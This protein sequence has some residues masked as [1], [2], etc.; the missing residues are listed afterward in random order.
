[1]RVRIAASA[2]ILSLA[3][4]TL[5]IPASAQVQPT[6][7]SSG[8]AGDSPAGHGSVSIAF[9]DTA[10]NGFWLRSNLKL[11][12]GAVHMLGTGL[13]ASY[14]VSDDWTIYG[15]V[16]YFTGRPGGPF[17]NCPTLAPPQCAGQPPLANPHPGIALPRRRQ[18]PRRLA[19]LEPRR[20][21]ARQHRQLLHHAV[22][23][24]VHPDPRLSNLRQR[25]SGTG[26][27]PVAAG[28]DA[29]RTSSTSPISTTSS[30]TATRSASMCLASIPATSASTANWAGSSTRSSRCAAS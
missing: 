27:A 28:C 14:N 11:P 21:L 24:G 5:A 15:G 18:L 8:N 3:G 4:A 13:D 6:A 17:P 22:G 9:F 10:I 26:S 25:G 2:L 1:M 16:R 19:G 20:G 7:P 23:H 12:V 29:G 30:A